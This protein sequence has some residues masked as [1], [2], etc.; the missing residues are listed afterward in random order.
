ML[1]QP[2]VAV[3]NSAAAMKMIM[4]RRAVVCARLRS[5]AATE[6]VKMAARVL[7][8]ALMRGLGI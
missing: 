6:I 8:M 3:K 5:M 1:R 4:K 7:A 2:A